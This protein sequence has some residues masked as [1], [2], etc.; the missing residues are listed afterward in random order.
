MKV[1]NNSSVSQL[2]V[3]QSVLPEELPCFPDNIEVATF[4][5][6]TFPKCVSLMYGNNLRIVELPY[7]RISQ[8]PVVKS[9]FLRKLNLSHNVIF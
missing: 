4:K 1:R 9:N 6:C 7:C 8:V 5:Q 3:N 2:L